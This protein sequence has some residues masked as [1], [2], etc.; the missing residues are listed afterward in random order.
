M[1]EKVLGVEG[2]TAAAWL[3]R[4]GEG[5]DG[6]HGK[7]TLLPAAHSWVGDVVHGAYC[8]RG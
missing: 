7:G 3:G 6:E 8:A 1:L 2:G 5:V 4:T